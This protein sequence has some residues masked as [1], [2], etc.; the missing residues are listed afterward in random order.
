MGKSLSVVGRL[1]AIT[2]HFLIYVG[3]RLPHGSVHFRQPPLVPVASHLEQVR[4]VTRGPF[5]PIVP[6]VETARY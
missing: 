6:V 1:L 3:L 4:S 5:S 2:I